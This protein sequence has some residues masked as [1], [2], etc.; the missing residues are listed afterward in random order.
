MIQQIKRHYEFTQ[1][2][3]TRA[4]IQSVLLCLNEAITLR[5]ANKIVPLSGFEMVAY[6]IHVSN[7]TVTA[8]YL[9]LSSNL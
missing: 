7:M 9:S 8:F 2:N 3:L 5:H 4:G 1:L 6:Q